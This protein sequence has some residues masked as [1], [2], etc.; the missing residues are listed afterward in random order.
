MKLMTKELEEQFKKV[1][2]QENVSDP[3]VIAKFFN[4]CGQATWWATEYNSRNKEFFG[5]VNLT[6]EEFSEWGSFSL[7]EL[8]EITL[9]FG[10]KIERDLYFTPQSISKI[11]PKAVLSI[12]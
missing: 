11:M 6:G 12:N 9:P 1:G 8:E 10:L 2:S 4:P 3:L 5:F 7:K